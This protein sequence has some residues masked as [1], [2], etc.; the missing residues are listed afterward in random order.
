M[1]IDVKNLSYSYDEKK[2]FAINNASCVIN[3]HD[4]LA[5][6]GHTG[7]GKSTFIQNINGLLIPTLG[8]VDVDEI[9]IKNKIKIKDIKNLRKR[10][11][12]VF[13]FPE[14]QL[15]EETVAKDILFGPKNFNL[16]NGVNPDDLVKN[17][18]NMVGLDESFNDKSPFELSG[19]EK[20]RVA[21]AGILAFNPDV[22]IVDEPTAGLDPKSAISM[23]NLFKKLN[24]EG[25]TI[26][27]VTHQ[28]DHVINYASRIIVFNESKIEF[29]G[30]PYDLFKNEGL[31]KK[32]NLD[33]PNIFKLVS[34][35]S[36]KY[37]EIKNYHI[38]NIS[39]FVNAYKEIKKLWT[40]LENM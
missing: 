19:G 28:M 35:T 17:I 7:S 15:F 1:K 18:L 2:T 37:P 29:D 33:L 8:E 38:E 22:L 25:K 5:I 32:L 3:E 16:L 11:G 26:I 36:K 21:I 13:Q 27:L 30:I 40:R 6:S 14:Y 31:V 20:R 10:I 4:F 9:V 23:M 12:I 34:L 39:Q 24:E